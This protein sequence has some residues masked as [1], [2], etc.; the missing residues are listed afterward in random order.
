MLP[1]AILLDVIEILQLCPDKTEHIIRLNNWPDIHLMVWGLVF[2]ALSFKDL[3]FLIPK[4][5]KEGDPPILEFLIF[6]DNTKEAEHACC[7][8]HTLLPLS[9]VTGR[10]ALNTYFISRIG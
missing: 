1:P 3:E 4:G 8:L 9:V 2:P 6:F 7:D 5:Y 10:Q